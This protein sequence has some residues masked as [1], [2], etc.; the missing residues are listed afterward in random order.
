MVSLADLRPTRKERVFDLAQEGGFDVSDWIASSNDPR[1]H[2]A[3]PKYCYAWSFL[4]PGKVA[5]LNLWHDMMQEEAGAIVQRN[6]F[7]ADAEANRAAGGKQ[8]WI[9]RALALDQTLQAALRENLPVRVIINDGAI[10]NNGDPYGDPSKVTARQL[11]SVPW[12][13][14][15]YDWQT[16]EHSITRGIISRQF[17]DQFALDQADKIKPRRR[18]SAGLEFVRDPRVRAHALT[19][20]NGHCEHCGARGFEMASGAIYLETHH[21][22]PL[23]EGGAD[24]VTNV[25]ALC[26]N[27]HKRAHFGADA[28]FIRAA[29]LSKIAP[30]VSPTAVIG[31]QVNAMR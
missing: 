17:V 30:A 14:T 4:A 28:D 13:I 26:P 19:R 16:G 20:A 27:D 22:V 12:T 11:D 8:A 29:L 24:H 21:V 5:I 23:C 15:E 10:R 1:G 31:H 9:R 6:N 3:N 7:R 2:K 25:A 18:Q